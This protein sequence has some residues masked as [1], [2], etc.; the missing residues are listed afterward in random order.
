MLKLFSHEILLLLIAALQ[1]SLALTGEMV[2]NSLI[3]D[4]R[5]AISIVQGY[6]TKDPNRA[7]PIHALVI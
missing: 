5:I 7:F 3:Q 1:T 6:V 2:Q 4:R